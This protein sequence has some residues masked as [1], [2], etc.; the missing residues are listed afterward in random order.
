[1]TPPYIKVS[2]QNSYSKIHSSIFDK[3]KNVLI[4]HEDSTQDNCCQKCFINFY[5]K[6]K[7]FPIFPRLKLMYK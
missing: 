5:L 7:I 2:I 3:I 6:F 1:M 4:K